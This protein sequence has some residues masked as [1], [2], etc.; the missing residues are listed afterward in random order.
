MKIL[1]VDDE[2]LAREEL[3]YLVENNDQVAAVLEADGVEE[4]KKVVKA[5]QPE[6]VFLDIQLTDGSGMALAAWFE[7][8]PHSP[9]VVFATAYDQ[10]ALAAFDVNAVDYVLKPFRQSRIDEAIDRVAKLGQ[11]KEDSSS[12]K[13]ANPRLLIS[14]D[15]RVLV[16]KKRDILFLQAQD[17]NVH[18]QTADRQ[19]IVSKQSLVNI[20]HQLDPAKFLRI[21]R[22]FIVNLDAVKEIQP[23]FNHTYELTLVDGS[24]LPVSR[25]YVNATKE[26]LGE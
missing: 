19:E 12:H 13:Q 2:P 15:E 6:M 1:I 14:S 4:A 22:S 9:H 16:V 24:K 3:K 7:S 10:Y 11:T 21:H 8:L 23:S 20:A 18:I 5:Y 17:G 25:S 26:A